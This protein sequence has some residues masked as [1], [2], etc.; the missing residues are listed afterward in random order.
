[1]YMTRS[2]RRDDRKGFQTRSSSFAQSVPCA[3]ASTA[4]IHANLLQLEAA[5]PSNMFTH[6]QP[7]QIMMVQVDAN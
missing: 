7:D 6:S 4:A 5:R 1:M 2:L 3:P